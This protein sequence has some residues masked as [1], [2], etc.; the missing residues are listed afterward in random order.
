MAPIVLLTP[1]LPEKFQNPNRPAS[2][3]IRVWRYHVDITVP[4]PE[5]PLRVSINGAPLAPMTTYAQNL[6]DVIIRRALQDISHGFYIDIGAY[7]S[8]IDS[9]TCWFHEIG[10]RG[11][12]VEPCPA[13]HAKLVIDRPGDTNLC[14]AIGAQP[15]AQPFHVIGDTG[16]ATLLEANA[17]GAASQ[18]FPTSSKPIVPVQTLDQLLASHAAGRVVDFLKID[19]EGSEADILNATTFSGAR[20]RLLVIEAVRPFTLEPCWDAWEPHLCRQGYHFAWFDGLN[21]FYLRDE[22]LWRSPLF[23]IPP[24]LF[25]NFRTAA[26]VRA[27]QQIAQL[28][29]INQSLQQALLAT[30]PGTPNSA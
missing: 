10:W 28:Q 2:T 19:V 7:D 20:P 21:R 4:V 12:N 25:D 14:C 16:L 29:A 9:V 13:F 8:V 6:E 26:H 27:L 1:L 30:S 18:G 3:S 22:D 17:A 11:V 15:G 24:S 23:G 5:S